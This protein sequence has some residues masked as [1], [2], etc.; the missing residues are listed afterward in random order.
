MA[1]TIKIK[2]LPEEYHSVI[3]NDTHIILGDEPEKK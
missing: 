2:N 3:T 1:T